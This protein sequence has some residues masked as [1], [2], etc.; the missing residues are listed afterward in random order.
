[1]AGRFGVLLLHGLTGVPSEMRPV[2][3]YLQKMGFETEAPTLAGHGGS[4]EALLNVRWHE[5]IESAEQA[6]ER[7]AQRCSQIV[8]IGLSMGASI[9]GVLAARNASVRALIMLS[10]TLQYDSPDL[11]RKLHFRLLKSQFVRDFLHELLERLPLLGH[12]IYWT[13][14]PPYGLKDERLQRQITKAIEAAKRGEETKFGLFRTYWI[15]LQQMNYVTAEFKRVAANIKCPALVISS[16]EDTLVGIGNATDT[17]AMLGTAD[18]S[19]VMLTGCDHVLTLDLKRNYVCRLVGEFMEAISGLPTADAAEEPSEISLEV[20]SRLNPVGNEWPSLLPGT[21]SLKDYFE[22]LQAGGFHERQCL[23]VLVRQGNDSVLML[24]MLADPASR[25]MHLG[26]S[27]KDWGTNSGALSQR[28]AHSARACWELAERVVR[29]LAKSL[30]CQR[31]EFINN[32][33]SG[34]AAKSASCGCHQPSL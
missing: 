1:M 29:T 32:S 21:A 12:K 15:S 11:D 34:S 18:K 5:W 19:L 9:A 6:L 8:V 33:G 22:Y 24:P 7:L 10:P 28:S 2:E 26:I 27:Q 23:T 16:L 30:K 13:E 4:Q 20:H 3:K 31:T 17:Y 25:T 14:M